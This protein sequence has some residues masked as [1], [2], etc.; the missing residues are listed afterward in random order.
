MITARKL[1]SGWWHI[2]GVGPCN[3]AQPPCWPCSEE[4]L[5]QSAHPEASEVFIREAMGLISQRAA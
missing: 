3:Y 1:E 2:R 4:V 5:R